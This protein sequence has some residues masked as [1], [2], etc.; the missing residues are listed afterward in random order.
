MTEN[1]AVLAANL[2]FYR[3]FSERDAAAMEALWA[4]HVPVACTHPGWAPLSGREEI[5]ESWR[6]ILSNPESPRAACHDEEVF[7]WGEVAMVICEEELPGNTLTASN[8]FVKEE[9]QWRMAHHHAGP[10]F[11]RREQ[12]VSRPPKGRLN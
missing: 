11:M 8:L 10:V 6:G 5:V 2:E 3:A 4:R 12:S 1:D 9:G 7:L